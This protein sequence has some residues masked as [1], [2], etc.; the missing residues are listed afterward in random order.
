MSSG[1]DKS[2]ALHLKCKIEKC[3]E[4]IESKNVYNLLRES[5]FI[6]ESVNHLKYYYKKLQNEEIRIERNNTVYIVYVLYI[7]VKLEMY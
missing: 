4:K 6:N 5:F 3:D 7:F 1:G 2:I